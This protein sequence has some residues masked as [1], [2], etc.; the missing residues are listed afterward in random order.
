[1]SIFSSFEAKSAELYGWKLFDFSP[2]KTSS[3][4]SSSSIAVDDHDHHDLKREID[5]SSVKKE[6]GN[7]KQKSN[8]ITKLKRNPRF[9]LELDGVHC[10]ET[11]V[12]Y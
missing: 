4:S 7:S 11:I 1:M 12:P 5:N 6:S 2:P 10:F 9:A 8:L 3:S